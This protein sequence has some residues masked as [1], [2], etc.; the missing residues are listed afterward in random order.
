MD[1]V[2]K[3]SKQDPA[4]ALRDRVYAAMETGNAGAARVAL[5]EADADLALAVVP[6][7]RLEVQRT[8]GVRL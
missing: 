4:D 1:F 8:Y 3:K 2:F 6:T 7:L 5:A